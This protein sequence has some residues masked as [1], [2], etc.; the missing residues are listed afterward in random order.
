MKVEDAKV[1]A[2]CDELYEGYTCPACGLELGIPVRN[3]LIAIKGERVRKV[4]PFEK[5]PTGILTAIKTAGKKL[6]NMESL[7]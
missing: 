6:E 7:Q 2:E 5:A 3:T 4:S 1:C